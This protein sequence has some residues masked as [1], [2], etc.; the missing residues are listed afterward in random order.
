[1]IKFRLSFDKDKMIQFINEMSQ[2]G[3]AMTGFFAGFFHF[4]KCKPGNYIYQVDFSEKF[5]RVTDSY[6]EFME[7]QDVEI[8]Q[9][10]GPW[11]YLRKEASKGEF[12][13]FTDID[14]QIVHYTKIL[15]MFKIVTI[16]EVIGFMIEGFLALN[17]YHFAI[18]FMLIIAAL[19]FAML[20]AVVKLKKSIAELKEQKGDF[21][22]DWFF[23]RRNVSILIPIGLLFN[24][25]A[26]LLQDKIDHPVKLCI[27]ILAIVLMLVGIYQTAKTD[28][29]N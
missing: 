11:V 25:C 23:R 28:R 4:E 13:M 26:L 9:C 21:S 10:W 1:M 5:F 22:K 12:Q 6:R 24:S 14:S 8:V 15:T 29:E 16:I 3:Y 20:R 17:G 18:A 19:I 2:K 7:E 27:Q